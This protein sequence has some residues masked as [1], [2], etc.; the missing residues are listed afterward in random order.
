MTIRRR[1]RPSRCP[2]ST[3]CLVRRPAHHRATREPVRR[4]P[5]KQKNLAW[6]IAKI[7]G[8]ALLA[9]PAAQ[10]IL[11]WF[12]PRDWQR[13][14]LGIGPTVSRVVPWVVPQQFRDVPTEIGWNENDAKRTSRIE[15]RGRSPLTSPKV[16]PRVAAKPKDLAPAQDESER[17]RPG[18][19][20]ADADR[21][22]R[23]AP[24]TTPATG[25]MTAPTGDSGTSDVPAAPPSSD[26]NVSHE[27]A[28]GGCSLSG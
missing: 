10:A 11:W 17:T 21:S 9:I 18:G 24:P 6:E 23:T 25:T 5:R 3:S 1:S 22:A 26:T 15:R 8:G 16:T 4:P 20:V 13:D 14:L 27:T 28:C 2:L 7:L 12:V 19:V